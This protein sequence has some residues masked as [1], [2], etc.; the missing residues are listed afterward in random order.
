MLKTEPI[1]RRCISRLEPALSSN[2]LSKQSANSLSSSNTSIMTSNS[3]P[4]ALPIHATG[5]S[6]SSVS[7]NRN[8]IYLMDNKSS[9]IIHHHH[10][11]S[12]AMRSQFE[13]K[14]R[15]S[16]GSVYSRQKS[17]SPISRKGVR[18]DQ[19]TYEYSI[20]QQENLDKPHYLEP[21]HLSRPMYRSALNL[22]TQQRTAPNL[23]KFDFKNLY[24]YNRSLSS[25]DSGINVYNPYSCL[26]IKAKKT[27][28]KNQIKKKHD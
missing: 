27:N 9:I 18:F 14:K 22:N 24:S 2:S 15:E 13:T 20:S 28:K 6:L 21:D 4:V 25:I 12:A 3:N 16:L 23:N 5:H 8:S 19:N 10:F 26:G 7:A 1:P 11:D 17:M